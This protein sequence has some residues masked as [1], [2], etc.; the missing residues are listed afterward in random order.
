[1]ITPDDDA[2]NRAVGATLCSL[3]LL[4]LFKNYQIPV[5]KRIK[6]SNSKNNG[7]D[8]IIIDRRSS[9][10]SSNGNFAHSWKK[11]FS[12][13]N[14]DDKVISD[15]ENNK[16]EDLSNTEL[17]ALKIHIV[18]AMGELCHIIIGLPNLDSDYM[19]I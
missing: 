4:Q 19:T 5:P 7:N 18:I 15:D 10:R 13:T 1:M 12:F 3:E 9:K 14:Q 2:G 16:D 8:D 11:R 17:I 6:D